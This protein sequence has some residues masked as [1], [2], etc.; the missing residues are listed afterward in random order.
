MFDK[1]GLSAA[2]KTTGKLIKEK[3]NRLIFKRLA[4]K[5]LGYSD[6]NQE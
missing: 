5:M 1:L 2:P 6:S 4:F 3:A